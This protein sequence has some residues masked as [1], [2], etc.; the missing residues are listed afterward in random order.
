[1]DRVA[2]TSHS[3][4]ASPGKAANVNHRVVRASPSRV[5]SD[6][7]SRA[8]SD[9]P[10]R[11]DRVSH[12]RAVSDNPSR[13]VS[14]ISKAEEVSHRKAAINRERSTAAETKDWAVESCSWV[15][16]QP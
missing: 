2:R 10:S 7:P 3:K 6:N 15:A 16:A 1:M 13:V 4:E 12:H 5:V 8:D 9:N 11:A 14:S